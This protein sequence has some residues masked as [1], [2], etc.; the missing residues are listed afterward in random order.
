MAGSKRVFQYTADDATLYAIQLDESNTEAING[1][2]ANVPA[3]ASRPRY[4][5]PSGMKP[6]EVFYK[7]ADGTRTIRVIALTAAVFNAIPTTFATIPDPITP[8]N[9]L[10]FVR[11]NAEKSKR[12]FWGDTGITDGDVE[13]P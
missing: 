3:V 6:R 2:G 1:A 12:P 4:F 8:A 9:T 10:S 13:G 11:K 5:I 7:S